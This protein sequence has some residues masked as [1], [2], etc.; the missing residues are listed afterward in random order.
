MVLGLLN[1]VTTCVEESRLMIR[2]LTRESK[3]INWPAR[4]TPI[5]TPSRL[6]SLV[7]W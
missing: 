4:D 5:P 3:F 7:S 2:F 1:Y 6:Q